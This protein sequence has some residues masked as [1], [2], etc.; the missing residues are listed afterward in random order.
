MRADMGEKMRTF[1]NVAA[2]VALVL[3]AAGSGGRAV[4][5]GVLPLLEELFGLVEENLT[6]V[7]VSVNCDPEKG[8]VS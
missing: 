6:R 7:E 8:M 2:K 4:G 3:A 5:I 1:E